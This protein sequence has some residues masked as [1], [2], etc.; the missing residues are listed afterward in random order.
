M[1]EGVT[2]DDQKGG[3]TKA[4]KVTIQ[5]ALSRLSSEESCP[6]FMHDMRKMHSSSPCGVLTFESLMA[7]LHDSEAKTCF[8]PFTTSSVPTALK[9]EI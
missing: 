2:K 5:Q 1:V 3:T 9:L 4:T 8:F 7:R 6:S